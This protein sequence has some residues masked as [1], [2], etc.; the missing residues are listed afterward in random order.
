M[1]SGLIEVRR[2]SVLVVED[3]F[4]TGRDVATCLRETRYDVIG[5]SN[6]QE[7]MTIV[8]AGTQIDAVLCNVSLAPNL[9]GHE[10]LQWIGLQYPSLPVLF[11]SLDRSA[12]DLIDEASTRRFVARPYFLGNIEWHL[13]QLI[14]SENPPTC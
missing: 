8:A 9:E 11:T 6:T 7:A 10:F 13:G 1:S 3:T 12:A 14:K 4:L 5:A 2:R